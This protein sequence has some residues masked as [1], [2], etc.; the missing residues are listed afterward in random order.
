MNGY[1]RHITWCKERSLSSQQSERLS[2]F[3][4]VIVSGNTPDVT[5]DRQRHPVTVILDHDTY[6]RTI[7]IL[8]RHD[9][10][11][12]VIGAF[13]TSSNTAR[14]GV[15]INWSPKSWSNRGPRPE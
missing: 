9:L 12:G 13:L 14:R 11:V 7:D 1:R 4:A 6:V 5:H 15:P 3:L 8:Q 10:G 2:L